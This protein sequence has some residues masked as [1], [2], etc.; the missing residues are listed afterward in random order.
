[1]QHSGRVTTPW[2]LPGLPPRTHP[3]WL[4]TLVPLRTEPGFSIMAGPLPRSSLFL[5]ACPHAQGGCRT[6]S[7]KR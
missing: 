5:C 3:W 2:C 4:G 1:M 7:S 6:A